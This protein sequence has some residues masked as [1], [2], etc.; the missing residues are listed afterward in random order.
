MGQ[1][2][3]PSSRRL[4]LVVLALFGH[5]VIAA[6]IRRRDG[7]H[8]VPKAEGFITD[9]PHLG[10]RD[11]TICPTSYSLCPADLSGGCCGDGYSCAV[12]SCYATTHGP[13]TCG[14]KEGYHA[15]GVE[16]G[17]KQLIGLQCLPCVTYLTFCSRRLLPGRIYL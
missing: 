8:R 12:D 3:S 10:K 4:A 14:G 16:F 17:G 9:A 11:Q 1:P 5:S 7:V 2:A 6:E 13:V 15:C